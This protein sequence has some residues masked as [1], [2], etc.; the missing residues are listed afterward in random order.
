VEKVGV[1]TGKFVAG[2]VVAIPVS[3]ALSAVIATRL[4][5]GPRG[6]KGATKATGVTG[7]TEATGS[8]GAAG[9]V[10]SVGAQGAIGAAG[11]IGPQGPAGLGVKPG[12]LVAPAYDSGGINISDKRG[13]Y[14]NITHNLNYNDVLVDII[15][16]ATASASIHQ[17]YLGLTGY[18]GGWQK[19]Y[20]GSAYD[21]GR[22][23]V[24]TSDGGY[25]IAGNTASFG[26][27][28]SDVFL[29]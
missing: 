28:S 5:V 21:V 13:Q 17:K 14:F 9:A 3:C 27:G 7:A 1:S 22:S 15:G 16:M 23:L 8:Q 11:A 26:A 24:Q 20:G 4:A 10:G 6:E 18:G 2:L 19:T 12:S 25:A 29:F